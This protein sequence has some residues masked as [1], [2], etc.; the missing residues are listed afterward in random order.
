MLVASANPISILSEDAI[1]QIAAGELIDRPCSV[2]K[3]L[4]ENSI[5]AG[6]TVVTVD[7]VDGGKQLVRV[8]DNGDGVARNV[9]AHELGH[10]VGLRH[11]QDPH[12]LMCVPCRTESLR[13]G[14]LDFLPLTEL[15]RERL[16]ELH[17]GS[18][19]NLDRY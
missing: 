4:I 1:F 7:I 10:T 2:V 17:S 3:E 8:S 14:K 9:I 12:S 18:G 11:H 15:D 16:I 13:N 5:D 19:R 6:S